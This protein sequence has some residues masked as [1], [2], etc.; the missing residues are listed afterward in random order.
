MPW[1]VKKSEKLCSA[2]MPWAVV[3]T[4]DG[5]VEGCH[6]TQEEADNQLAALYAQEGGQPG[7]FESDA[8]I[9]AVPGRDEAESIALAGGLRASD[10]HVTLR[11]LGSMSGY[12]ALDRRGIHEGVESLVGTYNT[13]SA[14]VQGVG[15]LGEDRA[16]VLFLEHQNLNDLRDGLL[17]H[18]PAE[19][20]PHFVPHL[21]LGYDLPVS[22]AEPLLGR[23]LD[24][25][26]LRVAWGQTYRDYPLREVTP[27][28]E[29]TNQGG[30]TININ[31]AYPIDEAL[32]RRALTSSGTGGVTLNVRDLEEK[33]PLVPAEEDPEEDPED[34]TPPEETDP[35]EEESPVEL[36]EPD[37]E[38]DSDPETLEPPSA[39]EA[40]EHL[41][42]VPPAS[43]RV[44]E[45]A[46]NDQRN[47]PPK[48]LERLERQH[49][50]VGVIDRVGRGLCELRFRPEIRQNADGTLSI[51]GYATVYDFPYE[52]MGGPPYGWVETI[53][54]G[55]C[56][57]SVQNGADVRLLINHEGIPLARTKSGTL[58]LESDSIGLY[59]LA[60]SLD[61]RSPTVQSL[62]SA[63]QRGDM[64]EMSFAFRAE[65]QEWN[66]DLT[67]RQIT[68]VK[69]YDVSVVT[70]PANPAATSAIREDIQPASQPDLDEYSLF[71]AQSQ[72][73]QARL[74]D[75]SFGS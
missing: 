33:P 28:T 39:E 29:L 68:Q 32:I 34:E 7:E 16:T 19:Q 25:G 66:E 40:K 61:P 38:E 53:T 6:A 9:A 17:Q 14:R 2:S 27:M 15:I 44:T 72:A 24:L 18:G 46:G 59:S 35:V 11:Y 47:L 52:V 31:A 69:L 12:S 71:L 75:P 10:L 56:I 57:R 5:E 30:V 42:S 1:A 13:F 63:M 74:R 58:H 67:E 36:G 73:R 21:T 45:R 20:F 65:E 54:R 8:M 51:H 22:Q 4:D 62:Y 26:A 49:Q 23:T 43:V 48:V 55:A 64:D 41:S 50:D 70:Y 37:G 60:P 3:K